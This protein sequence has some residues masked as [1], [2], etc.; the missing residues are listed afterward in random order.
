MSTLAAL[1]ILNSYNIYIYS[2]NNLLK[3]EECTLTGTSSSRRSRGVYVLYKE[4]TL[5]LKGFR[6]EF[7]EIEHANG[8][9]KYAMRIEYKAGLFNTDVIQDY[10]FIEK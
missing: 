5:Y 6:K 8:M 7:I 3:I 4:Q 1:I 10:F 9:S 2:K